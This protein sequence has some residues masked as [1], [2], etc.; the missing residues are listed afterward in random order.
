MLR[1]KQNEKFYNFIREL[2]KISLLQIGTNVEIILVYLLR[3]RF[4]EVGDEISCKGL[5]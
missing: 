5:H 2:P 4:I 3:R 1:L